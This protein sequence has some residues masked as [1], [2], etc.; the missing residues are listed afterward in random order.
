MAECKKCGNA[1]EKTSNAQKHCRTCSPDWYRLKGRSL[2]KCE[3]CGKRFNPNSNNQRKCYKCSKYT[4]ARIGNSVRA[5][6]FCKTCGVFIKR[7]TWVVKNKKTVFMDEC[8][9]CRA[10][11]LEDLKIKEKRHEQKAINRSLSKYIKWLIKN[12]PD[13]YCSRRYVSERE[14]DNI[15]HLYEKEKWAPYECGGYEYWANHGKPIPIM[16]RSGAGYPEIDGWIY[17]S[18]YYRVDKL[19][20]GNCW[21]KR[22]YSTG[23]PMHSHNQLIHDYSDCKTEK[24]INGRTARNKK[25]V[26][27]RYNQIMRNEFIKK[28]INKA[29]RDFARAMIAQGEILKAVNQ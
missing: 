6:V 23:L 14:I 2:K 28:P 21:F 13:S 12:H 9:S 1:F 18:G 25:A 19:I 26:K 10:K 20:D 8:R 4:K 7:K 27:K 29:A 5:L 24:I 22:Y 3:K 11:R 16:R 17:K 15:R